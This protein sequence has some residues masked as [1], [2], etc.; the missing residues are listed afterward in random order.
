MKYLFPAILLTPG[1]FAQAPAPSKPAPAP[2]TVGPNEVVAKV[3]GKPITAAELKAMLATLPP[4]MQQ[5][6]MANPKGAIQSFYLLKHL[7]EQASQAK[8][9]LTSP[10]KEQLALQR[11]QVMAQAMLNVEQAKV[12]VTEDEVKARYATDK[13]TFDTATINIILVLFEG[14]EVG[15]PARAD[16]SKPKLLSQ[17]EA[18]AKAE[19]LVKR[20]RVGE[21]FEELAKANSDD[22]ASAPKGGFYGV[23]R[24]TDP[25]PEIIRNAVFGQKPGDITDPVKQGPGFYIIR[26]AETGTQKYEEVHDQLMAKMKQEKFDRW[27][28]ALQ[29][30]YEVTI[31]NENFFP[32]TKP[33]PNI[34]VSTHVEQ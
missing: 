24:R 20:A 16:G 18:K 14:A 31:E 28:D 30:Q 17:S 5:A 9:E 22:E 34:G 13:S 23:V 11:T 6:L 26:V 8:L 21:S 25:L 7:S 1:L 15:P 32:K 29:K 10:T 33:T 4:D 2:S 19:T 27:T 3:A 12:T